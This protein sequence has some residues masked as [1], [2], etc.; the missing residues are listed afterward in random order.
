MQLSENTFMISKTSGA[1]AFASKSGMQAKAVR[2]ANE[3]AAK[4]GMVAV[5]TGS[6]WDRPTTGFPTFT[7]YFKLVDKNSPEAQNAVLSK[8]PDVLIEDARK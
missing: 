7:Y 5:A 6:E 4:R 3:F 1:G 8:T 2:A